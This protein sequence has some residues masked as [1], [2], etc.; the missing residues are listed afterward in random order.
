ML[1][2]S[3]DFWPNEVHS[4][5]TARGFTGAET[6]SCW[7]LG[8]VSAFRAWKIVMGRFFFFTTGVVALKPLWQCLGWQKGWRGG[9]HKQ[10]VQVKLAFQDDPIFGCSHH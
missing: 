3:S 1:F 4:V 2:I 10:A 9:P 7:L 5:D 8:N 6:G